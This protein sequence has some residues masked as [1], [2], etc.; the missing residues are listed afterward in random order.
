MSG[1]TLLFLLG[2][3]LTYPPFPP[4]PR[5]R[6]TSNWD[7]AVTLFV[8]LFPIVL[9]FATFSLLVV[10]YV[11]V[12]NKT[13][14]KKKYRRIY[15]TAYLATNLFFVLIV[16]MLCIMQIR[17]FQEALPKGFSSAVDDA[18]LAYLGLLD[19]LLASMLVK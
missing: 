4:S 7:Y 3:T 13:Q 10:Y 8:F 18:Y 5:L 9:Q 6:Y 11:Q 19:V 1:L 12:I 15:T 14:W 16:L 2:F 17:K